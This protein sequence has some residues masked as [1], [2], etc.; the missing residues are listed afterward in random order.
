MIDYNMTVLKNGISLVTVKKPGK[1][2]SLN[3]ALKV[4]S[5]AESLEEKGI[6]HFIEHMLFKGTEFDDNASLNNKI[7]NLGGDFNAYT[8]YISTVYSISALSEEL[9]N[10]LTLLRDM[11]LYPR[12]EDEELQKEKSVIVSEL[13]A[14]L[15]DAEETTQK[16]LY[17][18]AY[19]TSPLKYDVIGNE[20]TI[21]SFTKEMLK[22]FHKNH[23][24]PNNAVL[25]LISEN[26]HEEIIS[27]VESIFG[28]WEKGSESTI[29]L[30]FEKNIP[31]KYTSYKDM[32]QSCLGIL[33]SFSITE[34]EKLPL[35]VLNYKL[36]VSGN[37]ILFRE[38]RENRGLAYDVYSDLEL[39]DQMQNLLIYTQV[40]DES[41]DEAEELILRILE[42]IKCGAFFHMDDLMI[43]KK[44]LKTSIY[45][46]VDNIHDL[47]SFILDEL[48]NNEEPLA[49]EKDLEKL[50][51]VTLEDIINVSRKVFDG[52][53]I[54]RLRGE[55]DEDDHTDQ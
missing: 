36:G 47:S 33:Y 35:R 27:L 40:S 39:T 46:T 26:E 25:V 21:S 6:C 4:G 23:Y 45:G 9:G 15:D 42:E 34:E 44:V 14:S 52:P 1:L 54:Y 18:N 50:E 17:Y 2:F 19:E 12:F 32:E 8:D 29:N 3:M 51:Y 30:K 10:G 31:G 24:L 13:R 11:L 22:T 43:M 41:L 37:S 7:E 38:L 48:L 20:G 16:N 55:N 49:F 28:T 5:L 53:T